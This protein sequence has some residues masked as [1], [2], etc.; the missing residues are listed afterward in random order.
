MLKTLLRSIWDR[1][2]WQQGPGIIRFGMPADGD[3]PGM[4][5]QALRRSSITYL[6]EIEEGVIDPRL[7]PVDEHTP[8]LWGD[9]PVSD[10]RVPM[11]RAAI[12]RL[13]LGQGFQNVV[14]DLLGH[15]IKID[16]TAAP[17][18]GKEVRSGD[19]PRP[20]LPS[21]GEAVDLVASTP[22]QFPDDFEFGPGGSGEHPGI[23]PRRP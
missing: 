8:P 6:G 1:A 12:A 14:H 4:G 19:G 18:S 11:D 17:I 16:I 21:S 20:L 15:R 22:W 3:L 9:Q 5:C 7:I 10:S 23:S 13:R 2:G